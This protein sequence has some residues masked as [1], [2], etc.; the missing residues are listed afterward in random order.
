MYCG[1]ND[2]LHGAFP[3]AASARLAEFV[4]AAPPG[5]QGLLLGAL[6]SPDRASWAGKVRDYNAL[7]AQIATAVPG[8]RAYVDVDAGLVGCAACFGFDG[9]HVT[10]EGCRRFAARVRPAQLAAWERSGSGSH[11]RRAAVTAVTGVPS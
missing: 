11:S 8:H 6:V 7:V 2:L 9:L 4:S 5:T 1:S 10:A 3:K